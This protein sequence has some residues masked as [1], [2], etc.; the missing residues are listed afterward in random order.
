MGPDS[1]FF[2]QVFEMDLGDAPGKTLCSILSLLSS[3]RKEDANI[4]PPQ[5]PA[6]G[7]SQGPYLTLS[8]IVLSSSPGLA[9][10]EKVED[11][12]M[13]EIWVG[14]QVNIWRVTRQASILGHFA[15][16]AMLIIL[17]LRVTPHG[18]P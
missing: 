6:S 15:S 12:W 5:F 10:R 16:G 18:Q 13:V 3:W 7:Q 17:T 8:G 9:C 14:C 11:R 4:W 2:P 1:P